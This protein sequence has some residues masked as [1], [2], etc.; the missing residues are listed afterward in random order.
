M[1]PSTPYTPYKHV[2]FGMYFQFSVRHINL[3]HVS[4]KH[5]GQV[6]SNTSLVT[7][8]RLTRRKARRLSWYIPSPPSRDATPIQSSSTAVVFLFLLPH[9]IHSI[10]FF[11]PKSGMH[12]HVIRIRKNKVG[13]LAPWPAALGLKM[14]SGGRLLPLQ[15]QR[16]GALLVGTW[17]MKGRR[18]AT[19]A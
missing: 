5:C 8:N 10:F 18:P 17:Y 13:S 19:R 6:S 16:G 2:H 1:G 14:A 12:D 15:S 9:R 11:R 3:F 4:V 7:L